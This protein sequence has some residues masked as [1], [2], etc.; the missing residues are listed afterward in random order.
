MKYSC[1]FLEMCSQ[2]NEKLGDEKCSSAIQILEFWEV[3]CSV[4]GQAN[5]IQKYLNYGLA[6]PTGNDADETGG[7]EDLELQ[8]RETVTKR[9]HL[10]G[11][12]FITYILLLASGNGICLTWSPF[13]AINRMFSYMLLRTE[14]AKSENF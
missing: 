6:A 1:V 5:I 10:S 3:L 11:L 2:G 8:E 7:L 9:V 14:T 4:F 12:F 13:A